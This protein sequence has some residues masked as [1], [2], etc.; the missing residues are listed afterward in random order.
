[1][2]FDT[3]H[4]FTDKS[5][6]TISFEIGID[7]IAHVNGTQIGHV[8]FDEIDEIPILFHMDVDQ[9]YRRAGIGTEMI[10]LAAGAHGR[11]FGRPAFSAQGGSG[12]ASSDY[13]TQAGAGLIAHCIGLGIIDDIPNSYDSVEDNGA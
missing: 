6:R 12:K 4:T 1:M 5:G 9:H 13:F 7:I 10:R 3:D 11:R 8:Q 2:A